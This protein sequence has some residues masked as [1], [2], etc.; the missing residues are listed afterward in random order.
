MLLE[1]RTLMLCLV[2]LSKWRECKDGCWKVLSQWEKGAKCNFK[3]TAQV[4]ERCFFSW[5][6]M[7]FAM[8][9]T[10]FHVRAFCRASHVR[11][12]MHRITS[13]ELLRTL[14]MCLVQLSKW[15][16]CKAKDA[17]KL[18]SQWEKVAKCNFKSN[19]QVHERCFFLMK[20]NVICNAEDR[21]S[22]L[23]LFLRAKNTNAVRAKNT[24]AVFSATKQLK[25]M[26][27]QR[28]LK[29]FFL[30]ERKLLNAILR[31]SSST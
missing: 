25:R 26:Q 22:C 29:S 21:F 11:A 24:N 17:E 15:R 8:Q 3:S 12:S 30:S 31:V 4:H 13:L 16:E 6:E 14:M 20:W 2:Q 10:D 1:L 23:E 9:K 19:A 28:M 18:L 27:G 5:N 7:L